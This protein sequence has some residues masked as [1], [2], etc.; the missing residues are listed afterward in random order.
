MGSRYYGEEMKLS[1]GCTG[2]Q[3]K[4]HCERDRRSLNAVFAADGIFGLIDYVVFTNRLR[5]EELQNLREIL[6]VK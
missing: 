3:H 5:D 1:A 6:N 2:W 4:C